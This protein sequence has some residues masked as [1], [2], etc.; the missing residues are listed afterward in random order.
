MTDRLGARVALGLLA[1]LLAVPG[2]AA[3]A[4]HA[5][6]DTGVEALDYIENEHRSAREQKLT[7]EQKQLLADAENMSK[8]LRRPYDK[9]DK[10]QTM[11]VA[12]EGDELTYDERTGDFSAK[13]EVNILQMDAHRFQADDVSGNTQKQQIV[14]PGKAHI[15]QMTPGEVRVTLDGY[16][17]NYNYGLKTGTMGQAIGKAGSHYITGK[18]FEFYPDHIVVY[19][20]TETRCSAKSPDYHLAASKIVLYPND[21]VEMDN[22]RFYLKHVKILQK[23]HYVNDKLGGQNGGQPSFPRI[24]YND[25]DGMWLKWH[26]DQDLGNHVQANEHLHVTKKDGW[27]SNYDVTYAH[28]GLRSG[29]TYGHFEDGDEH[30]IKREPS[31]VTSFDHR[32]GHSHFHYG[33]DTE[34]GRWYGDGVHSTHTYGGV[35]LSYDPIKWSRNTLYLGTGYDMTHESYDDSNV[36]GARFDAVLTRDIDLRWA[37]Y[38]GYHYSKKNEENSLFN[39]D[40]DDFSKKAEGGFSYRVDDN[41]RLVVG[42]RYDLD[43]SEWNHVDYYW[44]HSMHCAEL[45][46]RYKSMDNSWNVRLQFTPW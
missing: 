38:V 33:L 12:F 43:H 27:R 15:L 18:R 36:H 40:T 6:S 30:W 5:D 31:W 7:A 21:R 37:A 11:P 19:D 2:T 22:V 25:D 29:I 24:G 8:H 23:K 41:N 39:Y 20:G 9:T 14:V 1:A 34:Y 35:R 42:T 3:A 17:V 10:T 26:L 28:A 46:L 45:V 4:Y 13:G 44:Y 32:L 16:D